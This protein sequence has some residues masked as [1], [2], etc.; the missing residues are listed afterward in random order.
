[1][2]EKLLKIFIKD[3]NYEW[4]MID[5]SFSKCPIH[6]AGAKGGDQRIAVSK[7]AQQ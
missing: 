5:A 4:F 7:K 3:P 1:V 2:W 6:A